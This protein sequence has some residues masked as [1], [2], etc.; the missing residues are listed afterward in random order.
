MKSFINGIT[1][2]KEVFSLPAPAHP[3]FVDLIE[4]LIVCQCSVLL[5]FRAYVGKQRTSGIWDDSIDFFVLAASY[6]KRN[7]LEIAVVFYTTS[8]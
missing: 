6:K 2:K 7:D 1:K 8:K 4:L 5:M 3:R